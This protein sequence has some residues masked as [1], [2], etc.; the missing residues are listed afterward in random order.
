MLVE[1][2]G[3]TFGYG[4]RPVVQV[5][6]LALRPGRCLGVFGPNG[7]GKTTLVRGLTGLLKPMTGAVTRGEVDG[8]GRPRTPLQFP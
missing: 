8:R 5:E 6:A 2:S 4:R 7:A 3:A 1:I